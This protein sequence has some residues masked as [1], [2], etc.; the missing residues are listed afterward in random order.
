MSELKKLFLFIFIGLFLFANLSFSQK[1]KL[2][3]NQK[4]SKV[5][6]STVSSSDI[7]R[8]NRAGLSLD[9]GLYKPGNYFETWLSTDEISILKSTGIRYEIL[10]NDW[11]EYY[12]NIPRMTNLEFEKAME[13][14]R[15]EY[16]VTHNI[17]GSMGGFLKRQEVINKIDSM[18]IQYPSLI[19]A[20]WSLGMTYEN[21]E[22]WCVRV[23]KNPDA[24]TGRPE[25]FIYALTHAREPTGMESL[26]YYMYW[27]L[28]NYNIDPLATYI[29]NNREIY[30]V[31]ILNGDGYYYNETTNPNGGGLWRKNRKPCSGGYGIDLNRN[32]GI[33]SFWNASN[34]GSSTSCGSDTY[35]GTTP[36]SEP[37]TQAFETFVNSRNIKSGIS[38]HTYGNHLLKPWSWCDPTPTPDDNI[39][40]EWGMD[41]TKDNHYNY[42]TCYQTLGYYSR[43]DALDWLY[44]DSG[45]TH[46]IAYTSEVGSDFW[47]PASEIMPDVQQNLWMCQ[48]ITMAAGPFVNNKA[49]TFNKS[50]Y[51]Q[52]ETGNVKIV[53]RN[54]GKMDAQNVKIEFLPLSG[55]VTIPVQLYT[56]ASMPSFTSDSVTFNFTISSAAPNNYGIPTRIRIKQNDTSIVFN[57]VYNILIGNGITTFADSAE[58]G[59]TNWNFG[60]GWG[61][62]T[63][64]YHTPTHSFAYPNYAAYANN[65]MSLN[66][67]LNL[68]SY[69]VAFLEWW[70]RYDVE[71]GYDYCYVEVSSDNGTNWQQV[72]MYSGT[73]T[74]WTKQSF[75]ISSMV[76]HSSNFR[77][78]FRLTSDQSLQGTGW[79]VDDIK[80]T[81]FQGPAT[82]IENN[83]GLIPNKFSLEQNF[84]NPFNP[85]TQINYSVA[86]AGIVKISVFDIL[87]KE[88][89][90]LVNEFKNPGYYAVDFDGTNLSSGFYFYRMQ[91]GNFVDTKK[92]S[93]IK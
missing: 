2:D 33:Y 7:Q 71:S 91:S 36:N 29:L 40:Y 60:T 85:S 25:V 68:S 58:N 70:Q 15:D 30:F 81:N 26:I 24:P 73:N 83:T 79:Y 5:R 10:I 82:Y 59:T 42:G 72:S 50:S 3:E 43:G 61:L 74:T 48:F 46:I 49:I 69:P 17:M 20:K 63:S 76:N 27:L 90:T 23:T 35:R 52:N 19:S 6:I 8:L 84:P 45:H 87:G 67:P 51:A 57:Q 38:F 54:K 13:K 1:S 86:K 65:S 62:N 44:N 22:I 14:S 53:F 64:Y 56:K 77:I 32:Y 78:R 55:L 39:F 11:Q 88:V 66:F 89:K 21:R 80:I 75:D 4:Y 9:G 31:P 18:R 92:M 16:N 37:E 28:E 12:N 34:G 47:P 93:L 41:M